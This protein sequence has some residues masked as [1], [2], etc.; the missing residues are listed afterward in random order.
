MREMP[1]RSRNRASVIDPVCRHSSSENAFRLLVCIAADREPVADSDESALAF[2][3][4]RQLRILDGDRGEA[5]LCELG[6]ERLGLRGALAET[7]AGSG[8]VNL[9]VP[10]LEVEQGQDRVRPRRSRQQLAG[11]EAGVERSRFGPQGQPRP[12]LA[13]GVL[14]P[15]RR[16]V[17]LVRALD[18]GQALLQLSAREERPGGEL[19]RANGLVDE[20]LHDRFRVVRREQLEAGGI[21]RAWGSR[22][23]DAASSE[24][25]RVTE[26]DAVVARR[27]DR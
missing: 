15:L 22:I 20:R 14:E 24:R 4:A 16:E 11:C 8:E 17:P 18:S 7:C 9:S 2:E 27:N 10:P 5:R 25:R 3:E 26:D 21:G 23:E 13:P 12:R 19:V 6:F 1:R